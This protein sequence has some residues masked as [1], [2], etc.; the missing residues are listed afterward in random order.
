MEVQAVVRRSM[1]TVHGGT[2]ANDCAGARAGIDV[3]RWRRSF[4]AVCLRGRLRAVFQFSE[5]IGHS[6]SVW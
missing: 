2:W 3:R 6:F 4:G 1:S 5:E